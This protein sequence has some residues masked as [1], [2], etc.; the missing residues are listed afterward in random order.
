MIEKLIEMHLGPCGSARG[1][2]M[3][4]DCATEDQTDTNRPHHSRHLDHGASCTAHRRLPVVVL[5]LP[6]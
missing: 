1:V 6:S 4:E 5:Q 2:R 3:A